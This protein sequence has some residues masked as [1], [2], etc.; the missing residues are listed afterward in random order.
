MFLSLTDPV[1]ES[2]SFYSA[3]I[4]ASGGT[5]P[6]YYTLISGSIPT[7][8]TFFSNGNLSGRPSITGSYFFI[9]NATDLFGCSGSQTFE[10]SINSNPTT[11]SCAAI[12]FEHN[13]SVFAGS[14]AELIAG[15]SCTPYDFIITATGGTGLY[16]YAIISGCSAATMGVTLNPSTGEF[17]A[18]GGSLV[19]GDWLFTYQATDANS[20]T[21]SIA[22]ELKICQC[23]VPCSYCTG[24]VPTPGGISVNLSGLLPTCADDEGTGTDFIMTGAII[25][26]VVG[27]PCNW[28]GVIGY[29]QQTSY[30]NRDCTGAVLS[31]TTGN[32]LAE[33]SRGA[34][35]YAINIKNVDGIDFQYVGAN[36]PVGDCM[37]G[38]SVTVAYADQNGQNTDIVHYAPGSGLYNITATIGPTCIVPGEPTSC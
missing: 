6:Y 16:T 32:I 34:T 10:F 33:V 2:G 9:I 26:Q 8:L 36:F 27:Q 28:S 22:C 12:S 21:A 19:P 13:D 4:I 25:G 7:G 30:A 18:S 20:C 11:S 31:V 35:N 15:N 38:Q 3:T 24:E 17:T 1:I 14:P 29:W 5:D 23:G 37:T